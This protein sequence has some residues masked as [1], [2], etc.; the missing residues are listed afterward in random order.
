MSGQ[1]HRVVIA[2]H[3]FGV[4]V[5][6]RAEA[7]EVTHTL[8]FVVLRETGWAGGRAKIKRGNDGEITGSQNIKIDPLPVKTPFFEQHP[9]SH[10]HTYT[11]AHTK[12]H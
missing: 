1:G 9:H 5:R 10:L 2:H 4:S 8:H 11:H 7:Q 3:R 6:S 12:T